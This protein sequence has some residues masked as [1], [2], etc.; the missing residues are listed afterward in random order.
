MTKYR[1]PSA[2]SVAIWAVIFALG[3]TVALFS[4]ATWNNGYLIGLCH[5]A[6]IAVMMM[7]AFDFRWSPR[8]D[9]AAR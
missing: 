1:Q 6:F 8:A 4:A 9:E 5:G 3:N 7:L 2:K